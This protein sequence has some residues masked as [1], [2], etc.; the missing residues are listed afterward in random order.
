MYRSPQARI[1]A[2]E[3]GLDGRLAVERGAGEPLAEQ[4]DRPGVR[5]A[6]TERQ[7]QEAPGSSLMGSSSRCFEACTEWCSGL[8]EGPED[9]YAS[10]R[11]GDDGLEVPFPLALL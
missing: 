6:I 8:E 4:P 11:E 7:P 1:E 9:V 10:S 5:H 3:Q 2:G